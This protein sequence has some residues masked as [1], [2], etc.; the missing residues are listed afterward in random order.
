MKVS[1]PPAPAKHRAVVTIVPR[2]VLGAGRRRCPSPSERRNWAL[3]ALLPPQST[4]NLRRKA[5]PFFG[6]G[7]AGRRC[8]T[9]SVEN[10]EELPNVP[11]TPMAAFAGTIG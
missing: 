6:R 4:G 7:D 1:C 8:G 5:A 2:C 3:G 9:A 11:P 10:H